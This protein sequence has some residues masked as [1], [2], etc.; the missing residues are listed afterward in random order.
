MKEV[1]KMEQDPNKR[2]M[3]KYV[4]LLV[5][6]FLAILFYVW[7]WLIGDPDEPTPE[8]LFQGSEAQEEP[9]VNHFNE[10]E[11]NDI[12]TENED[13]LMQQDKQSSN[14]NQTT[15]SKESDGKLIE[16]DFERQYIERHGEREINIAKEQAETGLALYLLQINDWDKWDGVVTEGFMKNVK[17]ELD[18]YTDNKSERELESIELFAST[19]DHKDDITY[20]AYAIWH[21]TSEDKTASIPM[22]LYYITLEKQNGDWVVSDIITP[23]VENMEGEGMD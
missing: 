2:M 3:K 16:D 19:S 20:G 1:Y 15:D 17:S 10:S 4:F 7:K 18:L 5:I 6:A 12:L 9:V 21:V 23:N 14:G 8:D 22:Q 11:I 13:E